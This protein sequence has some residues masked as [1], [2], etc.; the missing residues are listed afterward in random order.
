MI[1]TLEMLIVSHCWLPE[2]SNTKMAQVRGVNPPG[3]PEGDVAQ[4]RLT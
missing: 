3:L 1:H 4:R 2:M